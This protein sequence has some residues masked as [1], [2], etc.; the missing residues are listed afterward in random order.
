MNDTQHLPTAMGFGD[1]TNATKAYVGSNLVWTNP[2]GSGGDVPPDDNGIQI[3]IDDTYWAR[4]DG[5]NCTDMADWINHFS[6]T[7]NI[8][9]PGREISF[10]TKGY[11]TDTWYGN[12]F[13][14]DTFTQPNTIF[15]ITGT[16]VTCTYTED[17]YPSVS[18]PF[19]RVQFK[20]SDGTITD[21]AYS[22]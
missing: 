18:A 7:H 19:V 20:L 9:D 1:N 2:D 14:P 15:V 16:T 6:G 3:S 11:P 10:E 17:E 13:Q 22:P 8:T 21:W 5:T 4:G 12:G